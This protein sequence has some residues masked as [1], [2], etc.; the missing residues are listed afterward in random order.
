MLLFPCLLPKL[1]NN[2]AN[3]PIAQVPNVMQPM[4]VPI[5][6]LPGFVLP[7]GINAQISGML[8]QLTIQNAH[9]FP[10]SLPLSIVNHAHYHPGKPLCK[11]FSAEL[12]DAL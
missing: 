8:T 1:K 9:H 5:L 2:T 12:A 3:T 7:M 11:C 4:P 10:E 6:G